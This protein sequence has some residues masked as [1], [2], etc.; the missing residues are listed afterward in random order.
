MELET[1]YDEFFFWTSLSMEKTQWCLGDSQQIDRDNMILF[2][3][4]HAAKYL[5]EF[6]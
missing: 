2:L 4:L 1:L 5:D 3:P 6:G